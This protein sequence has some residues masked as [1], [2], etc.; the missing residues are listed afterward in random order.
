MCHVTA[1]QLT[2]VPESV[3]MEHI[4]QADLQSLVQQGWR[5]LS[6]HPQP[7]RSTMFAEWT[8]LRLTAAS[9]EGQVSE[10]IFTVKTPPKGEAQSKFIENTK[11]FLKEPLIYREILK[12]FDKDIFEKFGPECVLVRPEK[13]I[14]FGNILDLGFKTVSI[15]EEFNVHH[16]ELVLGAL[17]KLHASSLVLEEKTSKKIP[18]LY[19]DCLF[20]TIF[21]DDSTDHAGFNYMCAGINALEAMFN[22]HFSHFPTTV[23]K[24]TMTS[25]RSLPFKLKPSVNYRNVLNHGGVWAENAF[26]DYED[27]VPKVVRLMD[28]TNARYA[29]PACDVLIFL[30]LTTSRAFRE[31]HQGALLTHY[32]SQ[33]AKELQTKGLDLGGLVPWIEFEASCQHYLVVSIIVTLLHAQVLLLPQETLDSVAKD[34]TTLKSFLFEDRSEVIMS[35]YSYDEVYR[36]R[37]GQALVQALEFTQ[38]RGPRRSSLYTSA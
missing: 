11:T 20:E 36:R 35:A 14:I 19:P 16:C 22:V 27:S 13:Y 37:L 34:K 24:N 10:H 7:L 9:C 23:I 18:E 38:F 26:F 8:A 28:L 15:K 30:H 32:Y 3:V 21:S 25:I 6:S 29:P 4:S 5:L 2:V 12:Y 33:L 17:A 31:L 1:S